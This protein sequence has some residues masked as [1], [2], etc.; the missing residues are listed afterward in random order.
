[1]DEV[2]IAAPEKVTAEFIQSL[3]IQVVV[4]GKDPVSLCEDG[5]HPYEV[6]QRQ[7]IYRC[8]DSESTLTTTVIID[9]IKEHRRIYEERN[10]RKEAKELAVLAEHQKQHTNTLN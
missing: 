2:V 4:H 1:M 8:I 10:Q 6:P 3:N 7:G 5:T 9:R